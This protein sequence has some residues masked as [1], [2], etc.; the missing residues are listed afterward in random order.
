MF[1]LKTSMGKINV[2][3]KMKICKLISLKSCCG[4]CRLFYNNNNKIIVTVKKKDKG[5]KIQKEG[6]EE[7]TRNQGSLRLVIISETV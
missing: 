6:K 7:K 2:H 3:I 1:S 5:M 4:F